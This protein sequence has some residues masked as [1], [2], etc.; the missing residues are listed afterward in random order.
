M[1]DRPGVDTISTERLVQVIPRL[2]MLSHLYDD[3]VSADVQ[4]SSTMQQGMGGMARWHE[5]QTE[6]DGMV[7]WRRFCLFLIVFPVSLPCV[8]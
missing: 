8:R 4:E 3:I 6:T 2:S 5:L 1:R 7:S